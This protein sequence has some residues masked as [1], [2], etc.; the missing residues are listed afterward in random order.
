MRWQ[1]TVLLPTDALEVLCDTVKKAKQGLSPPDSTEAIKN[2]GAAAEP[3]LL[4]QRQWQCSQCERPAT[5]LYQALALGTAKSTGSVCVANAVPSFPS[6]DNDS[7]RRHIYDAQKQM[8]QEQQRQPATTTN[9]NN[10]SVNKCAGAMQACM[11]CKKTTF[12]LLSAQ[13]KPTKFKSCSRC[14]RVQYWCVNCYGCPST[15]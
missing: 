3:W 9:A 13:D 2:V 1:T 7:C 5:S 14:L 12:Y 11:H 8:R 4:S 6:C 15:L 10:D